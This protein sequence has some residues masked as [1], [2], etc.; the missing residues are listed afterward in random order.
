MA[1]K[2]DPFLET[3][4]DGAHAPSSVCTK[5]ASN[6]REIP[7]AAARAQVEEDEVRRIIDLRERRAELFGRSLFKEAAWDI[8]LELYADAL[9]NRQL[10]VTQ[11]C[12][13]CR[14]SIATTVRWLS[15][16]E[17]RGWIVR[18]ADLADQRR[19]MVSLTKRARATMDMLF[20]DL[21]HA[22]AGKVRTKG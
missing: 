14:I 4:Q 20:R 9:E 15:A 2:T 1:A 17:D 13:A 19:S 3:L 11:L 8:L 12:A 6:S 10:S 16:L 5:P 7:S 18:R 22:T 21:T